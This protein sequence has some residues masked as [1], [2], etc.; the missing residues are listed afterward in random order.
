MQVFVALRYIT[1]FTNTYF[2]TLFIFSP[3]QPQNIIT[4]H[5]CPDQ[6]IVK[7]LR[8]G[9]TS[10]RV[11]WTEPTA[12]S[13]TIH[14]L[15]PSHPPGSYFPEGTTTVEY[16]FLDYSNQKPSAKCTFDIIIVPTIYD[17]SK[18]LSFC[19]HVCRT[20]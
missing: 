9:F 2:L 7:H 8:E 18:Y 15:P 20:K 11:T 1:V 6:P 13:T 10:R 17:S 5:N 19:S 3:G 4:I 16:V 14:R 12:N